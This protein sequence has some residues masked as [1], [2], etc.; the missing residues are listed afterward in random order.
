MRRTIAAAAPRRTALRVANRG[1]E[2]ASLRTTL[3]FSATVPLRT[4]ATTVARL[5]RAVPVER[6]ENVSRDILT[7]KPIGDSAESAAEPKPRTGDLGSAPRRRLG[8]WQLSPNESATVAFAAS[9]QAG[10]A[11]LPLDSPTNEFSAT[12]DL[13]PADFS[14]STAALPG[15][16]STTPISDV[17][18]T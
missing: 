12:V 1:V 4:L 8:S 15:H 18:A 13:A 9:E 2:T 17:N 11:T 14:Q 16:D 3:L 7:T 5:V 6:R 10:N